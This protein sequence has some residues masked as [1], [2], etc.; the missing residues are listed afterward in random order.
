MREFDKKLS[1]DTYLKDI[2]SLCR[3]DLLGAYLCSNIGGKFTAGMITEVEAYVGSCDK[4]CHAYLNKLT[5]RT[6]TMFR[7]G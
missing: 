2:F 3:E 4:A 6:D 7:C 1:S 5:K